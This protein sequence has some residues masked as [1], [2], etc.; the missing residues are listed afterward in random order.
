MP[1]QRLAVKDAEGAAQRAKLLDGE[2]HG[3]TLSPRSPAPAAA[4]PS[5][6]ADRPEFS[7]EPRWP[8][9]I[10]KLRPH[11]HVPPVVE[12]QIAGIA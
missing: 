5:R 1:C 6:L 7:V 11:Q 12:S 10:G 3:H 8:A 9:P 4:R 2:G